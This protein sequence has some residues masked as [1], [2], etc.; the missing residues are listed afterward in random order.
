[1]KTAGR[2]GD[3]FFFFGSLNGANDSMRNV[4][5][6]KNGRQ[7]THARHIDSGIVH[8]AMPCPQDIEQP[9]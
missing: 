8:R 3:S 1:M 5:M 2:M 4:S 9:L 7:I 6:G